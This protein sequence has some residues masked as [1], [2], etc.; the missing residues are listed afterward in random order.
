MVDLPEHYRWSSHNAYLGCDPITWINSDYLLSRFD[1]TLQTAIRSFINFIRAGIG[2]TQEIDFKR[3]SEDGILGGDDF[4]EKVRR[5]AELEP[6]VSVGLLELVQAVSELYGIDPA[7]LRAPGKERHAAHV[8]AV[9]ALL[10]RDIENLTLD[11]LGAIVQRSA[12]G[13]SRQAARIFANCLH[14]EILAQEI[15]EVKG[16]LFEMFECQA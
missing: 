10:V 11:D 15:E 9:L 13:L 3:G 7:R 12:S 6:V 8:R 2:L 16:C 1:E 4:V 14:S 5:R